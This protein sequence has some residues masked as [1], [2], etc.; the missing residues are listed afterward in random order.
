MSLQFSPMSLSTNDYRIKVCILWI[1]CLVLKHARF[2]TVSPLLPP[3]YQCLSL[4]LCHCLSLSV[5]LFFFLHVCT[6][7]FSME[8]HVYVHTNIPFGNSSHLF[9]TYGSAGRNRP[10]S[11]SPVLLRFQEKWES[12]LLHVCRS[13]NSGL[14]FAVSH[15]SQWFPQHGLIY[16]NFKIEVVFYYCFSCPSVCVSMSLCRDS[17]RKVC[18][19]LEQFKS[20]CRLHYTCVRNSTLV[21]CISIINH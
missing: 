7:T 18:D 6:Y 13:L 16:S 4:S 15:Y 8:V 11:T 9:S 14:C 2:S 17:Q 1:F 21:C 3:L 12:S 19:P 10:L 5:C 20:S